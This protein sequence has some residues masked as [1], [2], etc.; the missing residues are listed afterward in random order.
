MILK[1]SVSDNIN[2]AKLKI[3][4]MTL[5]HT[6]T[7]LCRPIFYREFSSSSGLRQMY[8]TKEHETLERD[9][10]TNIVKIG[11]SDYAKETLGDIVFFESEVEVNEEI[12]ENDTLV[13]LESVKAT[14]EII[15]QFTGRVIEINEKLGIDDLN[16][17]KEDELWFIRC[18]LDDTSVLKTYMNADEYRKFTEKD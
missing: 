2:N 15:S 13:L 18:E 12:K 3:L 17:I 11:I 5:L 8:Y 10:N 16:D 9:D 7:K 14:S 4:K 6:M 1:L